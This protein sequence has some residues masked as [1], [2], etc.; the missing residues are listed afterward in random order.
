[1]RTTF[2][3]LVLAM[4]VV[5]SAL[6]AQAARLQYK[7]AA[8]TVRTYQATYDITG[9]FTLPGGGAMPLR[10][11]MR[12]TVREK[13]IAVKADGT[14]AISS[15]MTDGTMKMTVLGE[16][17]E[18]PFPSVLMT[19]DRTP[20][21]KMTNLKMSGEG[22]ET[23]KQMQNMGLNQ[24]FMS[25]FGQGFEFPNRELQ[26]GDTWKVTQPFEVMPGMKMDLTALFKMIGAKTVDNRN[27][28]QI[29]TDMSL[30]MPQAELKGP[31]GAPLGM[32]MAMQMTAKATSYFDEAAGALYGA[33]FSGTINMQMAGKGGEA[34]AQN[35]HGTMT[36][37]GTMKQVKVEK[38]AAFTA[39]PM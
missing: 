29:D 27:L 2:S 39:P 12:F 13:V 32:T 24:N 15:E 7:D 20:L 23:M 1:M 26:V 6:A 28:L 9:Q 14:A 21:G 34:G 18:L 25:Q 22:A 31:D 38:D 37:S 11:A 30:A 10:M 36:I 19:Y 33:N 17:Q 4:L 35:M 16:E 3:V 5:G 8:G